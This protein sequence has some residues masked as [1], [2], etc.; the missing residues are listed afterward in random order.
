MVWIKIGSK[1]WIRS[2]GEKKHFSVHMVNWLL[3][4]CQSSV[5]IIKHLI[6]NLQRWRHNFCQLSFVGFGR[7]FEP[8]EDIE[9]EFNSQS[10]S[11][12]FITPFFFLICRLHPCYWNVQKCLF[13]TAEI[14]LFVDVSV[15]ATLWYKKIRCTKCQLFFM[16]HIVHTQMLQWC[17]WCK[18][19]IIFF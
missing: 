2:L 1:L 16:R 17:C 4:L 13:N 12:L 3:N 8:N 6:E 11:T 9:Y 18:S 5:I 7:L 15:S 10:Q 14:F 19:S